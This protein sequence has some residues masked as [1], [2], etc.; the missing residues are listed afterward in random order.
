MCHALATCSATAG[1]TEATARA[2]LCSLSGRRSHAEPVTVPLAATLATVFAAT[3]IH[4][5]V[6]FGTALVAMP[7]L[8]ITIGLKTATPLV[9]LVM[10]T[11]IAGVLWGSRE[12]V[13]L[14]AA[15]QL[16]LSSAAG[17][18]FGL[19]VVRLAPDRT[20]K[21]FL[22]VL[23]IVFSLY[24]LT[25]PKLP[26][27]EGRWWIVPFGLAAGILGGAYNTNGPPV[28]L[29]GALNHWSAQRFRA[30]L[31]GFFLPSAVLICSG[32]AMAGLW[33]RRVFELYAASLPVIALALLAGIR[34][35]RRIPADRSGRILY[36][37]LI[38]LGAL[39]LF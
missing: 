23:L 9:G 17:I 24:N 19:L 34:M 7:L 14:R 18:P 3:F 32:H 13:D 31:Q 21:A 5:S 2:F 27:I 35:S 8:T 39:L 22:G 33:S 30:T 25:R 29:Y 16:V 20:V 26:K 11:T 1:G 6:G 37:A 28:V 38:V 15:W 36:A 12:H 4:A 10:L